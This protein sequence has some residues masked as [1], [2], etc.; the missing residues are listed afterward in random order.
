[1]STPSLFLPKLKCFWNVVIVRL[2]TQTATL[3][4]V[5]D[6]TYYAHNDRIVRSPWDAVDLHS[7][8]DVS[9]ASRHY[10]KIQDQPRNEYAG[11]PKSD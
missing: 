10:S 1:M 2:P 7:C 11:A 3:E 4:L 6:I 8:L 5:P 9:R